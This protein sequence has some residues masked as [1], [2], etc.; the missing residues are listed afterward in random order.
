MK[1][2]IPADNF[3]AV[4]FATHLPV[5]DLSQSNIRT[6][7][8]KRDSGQFYKGACGVLFDR[9]TVF[10]IGKDLCYCPKCGGLIYLP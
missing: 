8:W 1:A 9:D 2:D 10:S 7:R 5:I 6:C 3:T 4:T